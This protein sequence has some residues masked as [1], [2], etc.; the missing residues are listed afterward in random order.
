MESSDRTKGKGDD[1]LELKVLSRN[2][3]YA[4]LSSY[5]KGTGSDAQATIRS[6]ITVRNKNLKEKALFSFLND[7]SAE[8]HNS[9]NNSVI[10]NGGGTNGGRPI[11]SKHMESKLARRAL[12]LIG[13]G[14]GT[15]LAQDTS[16]LVEG[17]NHKA[18]VMKKKR[19]SEQKEH[20]IPGYK[21]KRQRKRA[22]A[23]IGRDG[24]QTSTSS[25]DSSENTQIF[26]CLHEMW[27]KYIQMVFNQQLTKA[28]GVNL[29]TAKMASLFS[30][31]E[32]VGAFV[33]I[34]RCD[35]NRSLCEN[36]G[37]VVDVTVNTWRIAFTNSSS[38]NDKSLEEL[39]NVKP[40]CVSKGEDLHGI[41][42]KEKVVPKKGSIL[43][44]RLA[45][46]NAEAKKKLADSC[47]F[48]TISGN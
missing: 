6:A 16:L 3:L 44:V 29:N 40:T 2:S 1:T 23:K 15:S 22:M 37:M 33:K 21:S 41:R 9:S 12:K 35:S 48:F 7:V 8:Y 27:T 42:W 26:L 30:N 20:N 17:T 10:C 36:V 18:V 24:K 43:R 5:A 34:K 13:G 39:D 47:L 14:I 11:S 38:F 46:D 45:F 31:V 4:P 19:R 32:L 25:S 28:T